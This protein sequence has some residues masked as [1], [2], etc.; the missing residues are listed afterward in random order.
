MKFDRP[1]KYPQPYYADLK[2]GN[3]TFDILGKSSQEER[4][5]RDEF[6]VKQGMYPVHLPRPMVKK[7]APVIAALIHV[8]K[9]WK[10]S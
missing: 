6:F 2:I 7:Y 4:E 1:Y 5:E 9:Y 10:A 8:V 3:L